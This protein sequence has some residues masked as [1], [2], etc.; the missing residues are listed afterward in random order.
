MDLS[1]VTA[2]QRQQMAPFTGMLAKMKVSLTLKRDHTFTSNAEGLPNMKGARRESGTW[3]MKGYTVTLKSTNDGGQPQ[4]CTISKD[5]RSMHLALPS[6]S[7]AKSE[8]VFTR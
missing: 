8:F 7:G 1:K 3:S 4:S 2:Q 6:A 5:G